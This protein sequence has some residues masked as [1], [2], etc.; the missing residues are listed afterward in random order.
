MSLWTLC[1]VAR[2]RP[3]APCRPIKRSIIAC[4]LILAVRTTFAAPDSLDREAEFQIPAQSLENALLEFS[5]QTHLSVFVNAQAL[6]D[7]RSPAVVGRLRASDALNQLLSH[8][9][10]GYSR[11]GETITV[12]PIART[13]PS[14]VHAI[15]IA[16]VSRP[17][18]AEEAPD[19][20]GEVLAEVTVTA[21][22]REERLQD[23]PVPVTVVNTTA[24]TENNTLRLVDYYNQI[25]SL[26]VS[27]ADYSSQ[28]IAIR[29]ITTGSNSGAGTPTTGIM[30]D[31]VPFGNSTGNT[32]GFTVPDFDPGDLSR[33][34]VLRGPQGT[35]YGA[36]SMG[37]LIKYVTVDP[38]TSGFTARLEAGTDGVYNG[39]EL[40]YTLR[41]SVNV[42]LTD[43]LAVRASAFTRLDPGYID[44]PVLGIDG[45]NT[46]RAAGGRVSALWKPTDAFSL[47]L[48]AT[49][50]EIK[51]DGTSDVTSVENITGQFHPLGDLQQ[52]YIAGVGAY[53]RAAQTYSAVA[54]YEVGKVQLTSVTGYNVS[55]VHDS[56]DYTQAL[57]PLTL[58]TFGVNGAPIFEDVFNSRFSEELRAA[59]PI[60]TV[61]D[62]LVGVYYDNEVASPQQQN[63]LATD[64][65]TGA[66]AGQW[67]Q[68]SFP[69][70][71]R[72]YAGFADLTYH[73]TDRLEVQVGGRESHMR[74]G[75]RDNTSYGIFNEAI[76]G[77]SSPG[78][79]VRGALAASANAS[80]YLF[81]PKYKFDQDRMIYAR[82]ASGYR[83][84]G[85]NIVPGEPA[86]YDPDKTENYEVGFKGDFFDHAVSID[87][88][89]YYID[90]KDIQ[91]NLVDSVTHFGFTG[92]AGSARSTGLELSTHWHV[93]NT[94]TMTAWFA[95]DD[96]KLTSWPA[97]AQAAC[98]A[99]SGPCAADGAR[100]PLSP[101][102]SGNYSIDQ[103]FHLTTRL[104]GSVGGEVSYVGNREGVFPLSTARQQLPEYVKT[105][106]RAGLEYEDWKANFY[107]NNV[108]DRRGLLSG[109]LGTD[110]PYSFYYIQPRLVGVSVAWE[111][112][113]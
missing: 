55:D 2:G 73:V 54:N 98:D 39:N 97:A 101:R 72:E 94:L 93:T 105:D 62:G 95:F 12:S 4:A 69:S 46:N 30:V 76:L 52:G 20:T 104:L 27:P 71:Y 17:I 103:H 88:S 110:L 87:T 32:P 25:P 108:F 111:F 65:R 82:L 3:N 106:L 43:T 80:T 92:N 18:A 99:G 28:L 9:G 40:G 15:R 59:F 112:P 8:T 89:I 66:L 14:S 48:S 35:L 64:P 63:L 51:G 24:L 79:D 19:S 11:V 37:G 70:D 22:K 13:A 29:G 109:G 21:Q 86:K 113:K 26:L 100:L 56:I 85:P 33:I 45:V 74:V 75:L 31:D 61:F 41:G 77:E 34:E 5:R 50:Q 47:K 60:G 84:G 42:P 96:A 81:T 67:L 57:Y 16:Q 6:D 107:I 36:S 1:S 44:N 49:Y 23:V 102:V 58:Q 10:M 91:L 68:V 90:W 83:P 78:P 38:S 53:D 7:A